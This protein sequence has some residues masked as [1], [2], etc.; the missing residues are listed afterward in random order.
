MA[1]SISSSAMASE[2]T[3]SDFGSTPL[4]PSLTRLAS[5]SRLIFFDRRGTG[6]SDGVS[7][8]ATPTWEEW[9]E[10]IVAVLADAGSKRTAILGVL[11]AGAIAILFAAMHPE[12]VNALI[13]LN[14]TARYIEAGDYQIGASPEAVD[15][16][17]ALIAATWGKPEL[18]IVTN[19]GMS[20]DE[21]FARFFAQTSRSSATPRTAAAQYSYILRR[22]VRQALPLIQAPTLVLHVKRTRSFRSSTVVTSPNTFPGRPSSRFRAA[23]SHRFPATTG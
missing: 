1:H 10:D 15:S 12:M 7:L 3:S 18:I 9:T 23:T 22:D 6:G 14:A 4:A 8:N 20:D 19:P 2:V 13:L 21:E 17:V 11:D 5:F 16:L